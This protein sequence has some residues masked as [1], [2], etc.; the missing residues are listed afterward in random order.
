MSRCDDPRIGN[1]GLTEDAKE[2]LFSNLENECTDLK[3]QIL[4]KIAHLDDAKCSYGVDQ[5]SEDVIFSISAGEERTLSLQIGYPFPIAQKITKD[6]DW[7]PSG[8]KVTVS[9][10]G[11]CVR[12]EQ[13]LYTIKHLQEKRASLTSFSYGDKNSFYTSLQNKKE[14]FLNKIIYVDPYNFIGDSLIGLYFL[15]SYRETL[16]QDAE[17][18]KCIV[19]SKNY[20]HLS[21]K[22]RAEPLERLS[23]YLSM[24]DSFTAIYP[25]LI[26]NQFSLFLQLLDT[27]AQRRC[28]MLVPSRNCYFAFADGRVVYHQLQANDVLFRDKD[29]DNYM[30]DCFNPFL[31]SNKPAPKRRSAEAF[32]RERENRIVFLNPFSSTQ[33]KDLSAEICADICAQLLSKNHVVLMNKFPQDVNRKEWISHFNQNLF[34]KGAAPSAI[35]FIEDSGLSDLWK[36]LQNLGINSSITVDTGLAHLLGAEGIYTLVIYQSGFWDPTCVRSLCADSPLGFCR[37]DH[38]LFPVV[39]DRKRSA[40]EEATRIVN[41]FDA[42]ADLAM[43]PAEQCLSFCQLQKLNEG[44]KELTGVN[45]DQ[46]AVLKHGLL[47]ALYT[48]I[49]KANMSNA[50]LHDL[51]LAYDPSEFFDAIIALSH[52]GKPPTQPLR[53]LIKS[54]WQNFPLYKLH[55]LQEGLI[56]RSPERNQPTQMSSAKR[57]ELI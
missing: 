6:V 4:E 32:V 20:K 45:S 41:V 1:M 27:C 25:N 30:Q 42:V 49:I 14:D 9:C 44:I 22:Y 43:F 21:H 56:G 33:E 47:S 52:K 11:E 53:H 23:D 35:N 55:K 18:E 50:K 31:A 37:K 17:N 10:W 19:F 26:D 38:P 34:L 24:E 8:R 39:S 15:D 57:F 13:R 3:T 36:K 46:A 16:D 29:I 51:L 54:A 28:L 5:P 2:R 12:K 40:H 7:I 48:D